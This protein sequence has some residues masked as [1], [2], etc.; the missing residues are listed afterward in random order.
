MFKTLHYLPIS[1]RSKSSLLTCPA[2]HCMPWALPP[3]LASLLSASL[4]THQSIW[5]LP[6]GP[7]D[8]SATGPSHLLLPCLEGSF[9]VIDSLAQMQLCQSTKATQQGLVMVVVGI[10]AGD[11]TAHFAF[12][13]IFPASQVHLGPPYHV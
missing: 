8:A 5:P 1:L 4:T 2:Q 6:L 9:L 10:V 12:F 3:S 11:E 13:V 7:P